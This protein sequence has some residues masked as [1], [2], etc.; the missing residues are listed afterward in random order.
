MPIKKVKRP[1]RTQLIKKADKLFSLI[2]HK[3]GSC[4]KCGSRN[5]LQTAHIISRINK[6]LRWN[7][8][9]VLLLCAGCHFWA[10]QNPIMFSEFVKQYKP[11]QYAFLIREANTKDYNLGQTLEFTIK[12]LEAYAK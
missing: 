8:D 9:N 6:N 1:T 10:H 12:K 3:R 2:V 5:A 4:E 11:I 7:Q